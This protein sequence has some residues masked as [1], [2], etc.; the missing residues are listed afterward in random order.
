MLEFNELLELDL[1]DDF[2]ALVSYLIGIEDAD[3]IFKKVTK[4]L[5]TGDKVLSEDIV[6]HLLIL[7]RRIIENSNKTRTYKPI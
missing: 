6:I 4:I 1:K 2:N 7:L 3:E 5:L